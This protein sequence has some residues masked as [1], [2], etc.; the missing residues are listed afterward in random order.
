VDR[1]VFPPLRGVLTP[2]LLA[3]ITDDH[4]AQAN[5]PIAVV[6]SPETLERFRTE[7]LPGRQDH[8]VGYADQYALLDLYPRATFVTLD[9]AGHNAQI[10]QPVLFEAL[11][12]EWLDRV[13]AEV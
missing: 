5:T 12:E 1:G 13:A 7:V 2:A 11:T 10:E 9:V 8:M 3:S 4:L 6:Q